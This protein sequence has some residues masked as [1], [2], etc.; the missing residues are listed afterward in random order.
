[1]HTLGETLRAQSLGAD[2][3]IKRERF[4][5]EARA[6]LS[7]LLRDQDVGQE[8][9]PRH[10]LVKWALDEVRDVLVDTNSP[11][12]LVDETIREAERTLLESI[13]RCPMKNYSCKPKRSWEN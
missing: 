1:V 13:Q 2:T 7:N 4:R 12:R 9:F 10:T 6:V 8:D 3:P 5:K 11:E